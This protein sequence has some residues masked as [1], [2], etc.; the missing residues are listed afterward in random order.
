MKRADWNALDEAARSRLLMR[1]TRALAAGVRGRVEEVMADVAARGDVALRVLSEHYDGVRL[2]HF[3]VSA[4]EREAAV[5]AIG[6]ELQ[7]AIAEAAA[8]IE[9]FHR[10]GHSSAS[11]V[12]SSAST[13]GGGAFGASSARSSVAAP[14]RRNTSKASACTPARASGGQRPIRSVAERPSRTPCI[15]SA[16]RSSSL[17]SGN[18]AVAVTRSV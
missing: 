9:A 8:R 4:R 10:V 5:T 14:S 1:P 2:E 11:A 12:H 18:E 17:D 7:N 3:E 13:R 15:R 16:D 6:A